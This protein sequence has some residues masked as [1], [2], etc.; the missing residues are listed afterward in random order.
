MVVESKFNPGKPKPG[1]E[2]HYHNKEKYRHWKRKIICY[3]E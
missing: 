1:I 3:E 2:K